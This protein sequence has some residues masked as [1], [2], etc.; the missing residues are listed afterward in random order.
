VVSG[1][2][3]EKRAG[4]AHCRRRWRRDSDSSARGLS[5]GLDLCSDSQRC[6]RGRPYRPC[7]D[8]RTAK[9][10]RRT[11]AETGLSASVA[12]RQDGRGKDSR[13][14]VDF[15]VRTIFATNDAHVVV[16]GTS[17][18]RLT[19]DLKD[20]GSFDYH[21]TGHKRGR[22][23]NGSSDGAT[24]GNATSP[25]FELVDTRTLKATELTASPAVDTSVSNKGFVTDNVHW[26]RDYPKD[27]GFITYTD[28]AGQHL[29]YHGKCGGRPQFLTEDLV[30][31]PGCKSPLIL[32]TRGNMVRTISLEGAFSYA[33]VS[34]NGKRFALQVASFSGMHSLNHER[35]VIYSV[36]SAEPTRK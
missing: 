29:L 9:G 6:L 35:F 18:L 25:G 28:A 12:R 15:G 32:D 27:L 1:T 19:P 24:F 22:V 13:E 33:G 3:D 16:S 4:D 2:S 30:F 36:D 10:R 17:V 8:G 20:D 34:Q 14:F 23:Q 7:V 31:E 11:S 5:D 26:I 21:A